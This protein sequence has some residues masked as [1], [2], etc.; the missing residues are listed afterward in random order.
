M[1]DQMITLI[2]KLEST[3][4]YGDTNTEEKKRT[5]YAELMS[6]GQKEF[7]QAGALGLKPELKFKIADYLD[8]EDEEIIVYNGKRYR[9]LRVYKT[10][11][12]ELEITVHGGVKDVG[13]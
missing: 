3:D 1:Y 13:A 8:Y 5:V 9:V 11:S 12:N 6:I 10:H 4:E 2:S 7:Y